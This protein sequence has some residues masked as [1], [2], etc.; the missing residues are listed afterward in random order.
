MN[1]GVT[2]RTR[3]EVVEAIRSLTVA[4]TA[5]LRK[6]AE[7]YGYAMEPEDLLQEALS[8]AIS[9]DRHCPAH[10][11]LVTFLG[12]V[13][14]SIAS[15]EHERA[16]LRPPL[17]ALVNHGGEPGKAPDP[18]DTSLGVSETLERDQEA[19]DLLKRVFDLFADDA[20]ARDIIEGR[21]ADMTPEELMELTGLD[22]TG[23]ATKLRLIR[24]RMNKAFPK[25]LQP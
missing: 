21:L 1:T 17:V 7:A 8:R 12:G 13:M 4:E 24:R 16:K 18:H 5:R 19:A 10:V 2:V 9:D 11:D 23:Y 15:G 3:E 14:R 6:I 22:D 25:G 20:V